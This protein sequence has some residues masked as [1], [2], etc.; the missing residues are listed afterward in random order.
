MIHVPSWFYIFTGSVLLLSGGLHLGLR[1]RDWRRG[2]GG[3]LSPG[4]M[5]SLF[6]LAFGALVVYYGVALH[7]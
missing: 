1:L 3:L 7:R 4:M 2:R 6:S 5:F